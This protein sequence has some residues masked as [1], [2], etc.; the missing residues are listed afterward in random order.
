MKRS[1]PFTEKFAAIGTVLILGIILYG[2]IAWLSSL[3]TGAQ[4]YNQKMHPAPTIDERL[5]MLK[6]G[7]NTFE[8][9]VYEVDGGL[10]IRS[11]K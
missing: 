7:V 1:K 6:S 4:D 2:L 10:I 5:Q 9:T 3:I 8:G 11:E